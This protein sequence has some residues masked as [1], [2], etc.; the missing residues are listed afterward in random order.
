MDQIGI[1]YLV[2][3]VQTF[4][5]VNLNVVQSPRLVPGLEVEHAELVPAL[6]PGQAHA[7]V[8]IRG[9]AEPFVAVQSKHKIA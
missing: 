8:A 3:T 9:R 2:F 7:H 4:L 6:H 1:K 5:T